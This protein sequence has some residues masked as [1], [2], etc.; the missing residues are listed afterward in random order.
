MADGGW[1]SDELD[2]TLARERFQDV[3]SEFAERLN[4]AAADAARDGRGAGAAAGTPGPAHGPEH[5]TPWRAAELDAALAALSAALE[6]RPPERARESELSPQVEPAC[7]RT[8][9]GRAPPSGR[10]DARA[11]ARSW[12]PSPPARRSAARAPVSLPQPTARAEGAATLPV[13]VGGAEGTAGYGAAPIAAPIEVLAWPEAPP[14]SRSR[15]RALA[16]GHLRR[17]RRGAEP[18]DGLALRA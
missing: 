10:A 15:R 18:G 16:P 9:R 5:D 2:G 11:S 3:L 17:R 4:V 14:P 1:H 12:P 13:V 7:G 8:G 6:R